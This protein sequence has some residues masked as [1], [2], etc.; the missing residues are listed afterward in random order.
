MSLDLCSE[1]YILEIK[2]LGV[3]S[4]ITSHPVPSLGEHSFC[5]KSL[6]DGHQSVFEHHLRQGNHLLCKA[7]CHNVGEPTVKQVN[8]SF[9]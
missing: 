8:S 4:A 6:T 2:N 1:L 5:V 7:A 9:H 3:E